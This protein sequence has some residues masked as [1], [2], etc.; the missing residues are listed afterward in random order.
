[1]KPPRMLS[2]AGLLVLALLG[3]CLSTAMANGHAPN[4]R[5]NHWDNLKSLRPGQKILVVMNGFKSHKGKFESLSDSGITLRRAA[6]EQMLARKNI[7][8]VSQMVGQDHAKRNALIGTLVGAGAGLVVGLAVN[9]VI[10][11]H[12][13]CTEG[14]AFGCNGPPFTHWGLVLAPVGALGGA[15]IGGLLRTGGWHDVY[16]AR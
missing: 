15:I 11:S 1:M 13:N 7:F 12:V 6:G 14:P 9:H 3:A 16:R 4:K 8:R 2:S 10:W 5:L